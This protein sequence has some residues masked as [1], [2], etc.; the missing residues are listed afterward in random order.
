MGISKSIN[1]DLTDE[2]K[3]INF[4]KKNNNFEY[5]INL[6]GANDHV[7]KNDFKGNNLSNKK[8]LST[9]IIIMY[10]LFF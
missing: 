8:T 2:S 10:F 4:F 3:V 6:H 1:F 5:L 7:Y 9:S